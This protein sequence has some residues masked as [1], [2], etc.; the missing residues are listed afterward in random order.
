VVAGRQPPF[1]SAVSAAQGVS[2]APP[3]GRPGRDLRSGPALPGRDVRLLCQRPL[4]LPTRPTGPRRRPA[5]AADDRLGL[6]PRGRLV[7]SR[8]CGFPRAELP[9]RRRRDR[10]EP[11]EM[12]P[13]WRSRGCSAD[14]LFAVSDTVQRDGFRQG[15]GD[16]AD[17]RRLVLLY[18]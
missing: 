8:E 7:V 16:V 10:A 5:L 17:V 3:P 15:G 2:V 18:R 12:D 6:F 1:L 9:P 14:R 11:G 4:A 13:L